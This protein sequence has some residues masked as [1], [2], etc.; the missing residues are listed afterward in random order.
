MRKR[1]TF[2]AGG[3]LGLQQDDSPASTGAGN[4]KKNHQQGKKCLTTLRK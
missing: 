4:Q 3:L 1:R 2:I